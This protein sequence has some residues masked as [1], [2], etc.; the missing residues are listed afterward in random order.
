MWI[1][2][3]FLINP[4]SVETR[5]TK[6]SYIPDSYATESECIE[7]GDKWADIFNYIAE[8]K[9]EGIR[10][11]VYSCQFLNK[12]PTPKSKKVENKSFGSRGIVD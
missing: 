3:A 9:K 11:L 2:V 12:I 5:L 1:L 6:A 4:D 10:R 8:N 7:A